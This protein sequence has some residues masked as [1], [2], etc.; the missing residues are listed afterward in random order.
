M[1]L[2]INE[3]IRNIEFIENERNEIDKLIEIENQNYKNFHGRHRICDQERQP[4]EMHCR[5]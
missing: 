5:Q 4:F 3:F 1:N 2:K